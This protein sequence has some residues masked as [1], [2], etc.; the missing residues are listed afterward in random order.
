MWATYKRLVSNT[1][2]ANVVLGAIILLAVLAAFSL[3]RESNPQ[4]EFPIIEVVVQYPG[5]DPLEVEDGIARKLEAAVDSIQGVKRYY[6]NSLEGVARLEVEIADGYDVRDVKDKI[7][8]AIDGIEDLP[9]KSEPPRI[10]Q[11]NDDEEVMLV[12]LWGSLPERQLKDLAEKIR[13]DI[14]ALPDASLAYLHGSREYELHVEVSEERL[15]QLDLTLSDVSNAI[16]AGSR[17]ASAGSMELEGE[18]IRLRTAGERKTADAI[19]EIVVKSSP[20]GGL[21]RVGDIATLRDDFVELERLARFNGEPAIA[22]SVRKSPGEDSITIYNRVMEYIEATTPTLPENVQISAGFDNVEFI[23]SQI[24]MITK[25]GLLGLFLV[26]ITLWLFLEPR[27]AFWV[28]MGIPISIGG[29]LVLLWLIGASLNQISLVGMIVVMGIIVD[30]AIVVGESIFVHRKRGKSALDAAIDGLRE[31]LV[32]VT[33]SAMTTIAAFAPLIFIPGIFGQFSKQMPIVVIAALTVSLVECF[34]LLPAHLNHETHEHKHPRAR[35]PLA[36]RKSVADGLERFVEK[37]YVPLVR[38]SVKNRYVTLCAAIAII[39]LSVGLVGGGFVPVMMWPGVEA[40]FAQAYVEFPPGTPRAVVFDAVNR[41]ESAAAILGGRLNTKNGDPFV[42]HTFS[43]SPSRV[44]TGGRVLLELTPTTNRDV[45]SSEFMAEWSKA[46]GALPGALVV[47]FEGAEIGGGPGEDIEFWLLGENVASVRAASD[48]LKEELRRYEGIYAIQDNFRPGKKELEVSLRPSATTLGIT[49][50]DLNRH[51]YAGY[52]GEEAF[53]IQRGR[54]DVRVKVRYPRSERES[55][56][57]L[58]ATRVTTPAGTKVP[59]LAVGDVRFTEGVSSISGIDGTRGVRVSASVDRKAASPAELNAMLIETVLPKIEQEHP[60]VRWSLSGSEQENREVMGAMRRNLL[61]SMM[62]IFV[63][64]CTV[65]R[66]YAQPFIIMLII[67][68]GV[69]GA[70]LGHLLFGLPLSFL[71]LGGMIALC[72]VLVNDS[73][74]LIERANANLA[75]GMN[76]V[77]AVCR[78]GQR[79]FRAILLTSLSTCVGLFPLIMESDLQAQ[80]VIPM[81]VSIASGVAVGTLL[82]LVLIPAFLVIMNDMRRCG[83]RALRGTWPTPEEVEPA[84]RREPALVTT[85]VS[86]TPATAR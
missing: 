60:G 41:V 67:P 74:V 13:K 39:L 65:F 25:N 12:V 50:D 36:L 30:D 56:D 19:A 3:T 73:I 64:L 20:D 52:F 79:R 51:L 70:L 69:V 31:V 16:R 28:A 14:E 5:A 43:D 83:H 48:A 27:L 40:D 37:Y 75:K 45:T 57:R 82:T 2:F 53:R 77:D 46:I 22:I 68:Y 35:S 72:G 9:E 62:T 84:T 21:V 23:R 29:S 86:V 32:P 59:F 7:T 10:V 17:D 33:A 54:E 66:S 71:S 63:I 47:S 81:A 49:L 6:T 38:W 85:P 80:V 8:N 24:N 61:I 4:I 15:R 76:L 55:L 11:M 78:A 44:D 58:Y 34:F 42:R 18:S 1:V 26:V